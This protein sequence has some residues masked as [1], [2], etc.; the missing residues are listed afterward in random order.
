VLF[1]MGFG[2][3]V[4]NSMNCGQFILYGIVII[5]ICNEIMTIV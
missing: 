4:K 1:S 3:F 5:V 2:S